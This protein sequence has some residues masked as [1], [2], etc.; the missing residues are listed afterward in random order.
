MPVTWIKICGTTSLHDAQLGV[1]T[2]ADALGFVFAPSPRRIEIAAAAEI[3]KGLPDSIERIGVFVNGAPEQLAEVAEA[4]GL[5]GV[6]LHGD[7]P[8]ALLPRFRRMLGRRTIVKTLHAGQLLGAARNGLEEYLAARDSVDAI[9]LDSGSPR[10]RG[11]TGVAFPWEELAGLAAT[12]RQALPLVIAGGLTAGNV[13]R[14]LEL[15]APWGVD[16][17]TGV[18]RAPGQKDEAKL[19]DFVAAARATKAAVK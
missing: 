13:A 5:T 18:E 2:G 3:V 7:E 6:Q 19:R 14:A 1:A 10:Q 8:A 12:I 11:G 16:V 4:A 9:L 15:F 17:V